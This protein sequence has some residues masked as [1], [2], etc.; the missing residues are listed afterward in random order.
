VT[1]QAPSEADS[2]RPTTPSSAVPPVASTRI[3]PVSTPGKPRARPDVP[4]VPIIPAIPQ[5]PALPRPGQRVSVSAASVSTKLADAAKSPIS[6]DEAPSAVLQAAAEVSPPSPEQTSI[7][8]NP[9]VKA[10]PKSWADLVRTK[11]SHPAASPKSAGLDSTVHLN[12]SGTSK[13]GSIVDVLSSFGAPSSTD[14][15]KIAF[16]EPR[17]LVN[18]G[19]MCYMNAVSN[20][21]SV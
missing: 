15:S 7:T 3:Q 4:L 8:T 21:L 16:L 12:G 13:A 5:I 18:T 10:P 14:D 11:T 9:P 1:S 6:V 2:T 20:C 17:G 19:N